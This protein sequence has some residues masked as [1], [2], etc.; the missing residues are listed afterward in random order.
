KNFEKDKWGLTDILKAADRRI[1]VRRLSRLKS[2][3]QNIAAGKVIDERRFKRRVSATFEDVNHESRVDSG[4]KQSTPEELE[5]IEHVL[6]FVDEQPAIK[7]EGGES[8]EEKTCEEA[9]EELIKLLIPN[10]Q[11]VIFLT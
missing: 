2:K 3:T 10:K 4:F 8:G 1:G 6:D 11:V 5:M 9:L 7:Q